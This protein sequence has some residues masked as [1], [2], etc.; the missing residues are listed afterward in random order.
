MQC[1]GNDC[2]PQLRLASPR[3]HEQAN[4]SPV[5]RRP[6]PAQPSKRLTSPTSL[7]LVGQPQA[8]PLVVLRRLAPAHVGTRHA[9]AAATQAQAHAAAA[10]AAAQVAHAG[11][12]GAAAGVH[13][14][15]RH[16]LVGRGVVCKAAAAAARAHPHRGQRRGVGLRLLHLAWPAGGWAAGGLRKADGRYRNWV[17]GSMQ[18]APAPHLL[19]ATV[20]GR[21]PR[22]ASMPSMAPRLARPAPL[23]RPMPAR[24]GP[25]P[26]LP[27]STATWRRSCS[28]SACITAHPSF[29]FLSCLRVCGCQGSSACQGWVQGRR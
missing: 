23:G 17:H 29:I 20:P 6:T 28:F 22:P 8:G 18:A 10:H 16:G 11:A 24:P 1:N 7:L 15:Q 12:A 21:R 2:C 5:F 13:L 25:M 26:P 27:C 9:H 3:L 19:P 14:A 4:P